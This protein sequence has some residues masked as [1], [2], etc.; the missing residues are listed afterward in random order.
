[1]FSCQTGHYLP[2]KEAVRP[3]F[4]VNFFF[5]LLNVTVQRYLNSLL[6]NG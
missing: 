1:M 5:F 2:S 3:L 4:P 6:L